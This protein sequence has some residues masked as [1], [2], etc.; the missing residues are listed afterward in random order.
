MFRDSLFKC[1]NLWFKGRGI[2]LYA[3]ARDCEIG[4]DLQLIHDIPEMEQITEQFFSA[5]EN[6]IFRSLPKSQKKCAF[7]MGWICKEAFIKALGEGL[8]QP[9]DKFDVLLAMGVT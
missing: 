9:L 4:V 8:Y 5:K 2:A 1:S 7:F 3:F 6:E